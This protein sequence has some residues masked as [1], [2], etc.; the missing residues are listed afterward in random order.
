[1][2]LTNKYA[3]DH[4]NQ[5]DEQ[6]KN[7]A[8]RSEDLSMTVAMAVGGF[9][10]L[11]HYEITPLS[12]FLKGYWPGCS[13]TALPTIYIMPGVIIA[14]CLYPVLEKWAPAPFVRLIE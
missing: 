2:L 12:A 14:L 1:M 11:R 7:D 9:N 10:K 6:Y 5:Q 8:C 4:D 13:L 3:A